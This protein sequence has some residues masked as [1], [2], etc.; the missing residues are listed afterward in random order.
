VSVLT[1]GKEYAM[2]VAQPLEACTPLQNDAAAVK[3]AIV[4]VQRGTCAFSEKAQAAQDAGAAGVLIYDN[5]L[6]AYFT[7]G[8][9]DAVG[10]CCWQGLAVVCSERVGMGVLMQLAYY[11]KAAALPGCSHAVSSSQPTRC[12]A[13]LPPARSGVHHH[14]SHVGDAPPRPVPGGL[15]WA[16]AAAAARGWC[17]ECMPAHC[18]PAVQQPQ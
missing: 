17:A 16:A 14:P 7:W 8:G 5:V 3:G 15:R 2:V 9:D 18:G 12:P 1:G 13:P 11:R 4:L 10:A 6:Q